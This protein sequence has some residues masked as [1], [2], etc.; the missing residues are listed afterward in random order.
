[1]VGSLDPIFKS[2]KGWQR[3]YL[4]LPG[5]GKT[6]GIDWIQS[7]DDVL[8][9]V[10]GFI[11]KIIPKKQFLVAGLSYGGYLAQGLVNKKPDL[12]DGLLLIVPRI[13]GNRQKRALPTKTVIASEADFL[14]E[15][16]PLD[17]EAFTDVMV[18]QTRQHW[19][20]YFQEIIPAVKNADNTFLERL[21]PNK[22]EFSFA[23]D[24][25]S[26]TYDKPTL[27]IVGRQ[28]HWV[29]YRDAWNLLEHYPR[30]TFAVLDRAGHAL[31]LE[32][33]T[34]FNTLVGEWLN[35]VVEGARGGLK[36][37]SSGTTSEGR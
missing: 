33:S 2:R 25:P 28:D 35:R 24:S 11:D 4:D 6:P 9:L 14:A 12:V 32:Q 26:F 21:D 23:I 20:R 10:F 36:A 29:G 30:S 17:R 31:T 22:D 16:S 3:I 13:I 7:S 37:G 19:H 5:H 27:I 1:M 18:I 8:D 15:L 34:L